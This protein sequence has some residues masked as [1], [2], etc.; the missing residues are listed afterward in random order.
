MADRSLVKLG[1]SLLNSPRLADI[2]REILRLRSKRSV[3]FTVG[4]G[5]TVDLV[6]RWDEVH[7]LGE[8]VSHWLA[9][10]A[11]GVNE[12]LLLRLFPE[13]RLVR[14]LKQLEAAEVDGKVPLICTHCFFK[15]GEQTAGPELPHTWEVTSDSIAVWFARLVGASE[16]ILVKS[17]DWVSGATWEEA[18]RQGLLDAHFEAIATLPLSIRWINGRRDPLEVATCRD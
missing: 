15:W 12:E 13:M 3:V 9:L 5:T 6:R 11:I 16:L 17:V 7:R 18:G 2:V 4:G 14:S 8:E 10:E 1:G